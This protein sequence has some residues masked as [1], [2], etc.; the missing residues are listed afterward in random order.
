MV[1]RLRFRIPAG[2]AGEFSS[3]ESMLRADSY[4]VSVP[5]ML[6]QWHAKDPGQSAK[7]AGCRLHLN[8]HIPLTQRSQSGLSMLLSRHSM[9]HIRKRSHTQLSGNIR[10]QSSQLAEPPWTDPG[11]MSGISVRELTISHATIREHSATVVSA[12]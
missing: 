10:L 1:E 6:P 7:S 8:T 4:S 9:E 5:P 12:C 2:V 3:S 11:I